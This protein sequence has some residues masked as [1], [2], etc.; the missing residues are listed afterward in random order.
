[1]IKRLI[2]YL[3]H[4]IPRGSAVRH[5]AILVSGT[6]MGQIAVVAASPIVTRLYTPEE[7]GVLGVYIALLGII[8]VI[9]GLRY[10]FAI[11][12]PKSIIGAANLL[13]LSLVC[14]VITSALLTS[15]IFIFYQQIPCWLH[16]PAIATYLWILPI[17][18]FL[19]GLFQSFNYWAIRRKNFSGIALTSV[20]QG[21]GG[22][23]AQ[24]VLGYYG[25]GATGLITGQIIGQ[26]A[27][28]SALVKGAY[29]N[30][31]VQLKKLS[32]QRITLMAKRY[33]RFPKYTTWQAM[34]NTSSAMLPLILFASLL[35]PAIAGLYMLAQRTLSMPLSL[36]GRSIGQVFHSRA[37]EAYHEGTLDQLTLKAFQRLLRVG[38][39]PLIFIGVLA[40]DLFAL[41]FG[42]KWR[43]SGI[44][45]QW[46]VPWLVAQFVVSPLSIVSSVTGHQVGELVS[47][48]I[49]VVVRIGALLFG[50]IIVGKNMAIEFFAVSGLL[51]Y[52]GFFIWMM[53]LLKITFSRVVNEAWPALRWGSLLLLASLLIKYIIMTVGQNP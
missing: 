8:G 47:Q 40:P 38:L 26:C 51:V 43:Q 28:L 9:A 37:A 10:E 30:D 31:K 21:V 12:L 14:V 4:Y 33:S 44:Y 19:T 6:A 36:V 5:V 42:E 24:L 16:T 22:A 11:P 15:F 1:M 32:W 34:A 2:N 48:I 41:F 17:G 52:T 29:I 23:A 18:V 53:L 35:S 3:T 46:M 25:F 50:T 27:G 7:F 45:A 13:A 20:Q 39:G 49:F